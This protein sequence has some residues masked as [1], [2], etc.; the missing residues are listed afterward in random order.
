LRPACTLRGTGTN[1]DSQSA[2][3]DLWEVELSWRRG[4]SAR[5][6]NA[7]IFHHRGENL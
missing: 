5:R 1:S 7:A 2:P 3:L 4:P 6:D